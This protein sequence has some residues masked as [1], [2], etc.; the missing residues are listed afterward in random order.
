MHPG[1]YFA[2]SDRLSVYC[3][4]WTAKRDALYTVTVTVV[5]DCVQ[6]ETDQARSRA[7][8]NYGRP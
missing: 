8:D 7:I 6:R 2:L 4:Y 3:E 1:L 5:R